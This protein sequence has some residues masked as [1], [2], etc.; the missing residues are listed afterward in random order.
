MSFR[1]VGW[2]S[3]RPRC[4]SSAPRPLHLRPPPRHQHHCPG[5]PA[6]R[7]HHLGRND[8][9]IYHRSQNDAKMLHQHHNAGYLALGHIRQPSVGM[10]RHVHSGSSLRRSPS[11]RHLRPQP[12]SDAIPRPGRNGRHPRPR[13]S[14]S[15]RSGSHR[16]MCKHHR[17]FCCHRRSMDWC[18][19]CKLP[20]ECPRDHFRRGRS[21]F[22]CQHRL[23]VRRRAATSQCGVAAARHP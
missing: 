12:R 13:P 2:I 5:R 18:S 14:G 21:G 4:C 19:L 8:D 9:R 6:R 20:R 17:R 10:Y 11:N 16:R 7:R 15:R 23:L 3:S 1:E 22:R